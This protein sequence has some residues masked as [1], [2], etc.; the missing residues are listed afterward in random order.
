M[1]RPIGRRDF[2]NGVAV[3]IGVLGSG[4]AGR[5]GARQAAA[6]PGRRTRPVITRRC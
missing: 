1:H 6:W 2:L 5:R 3:G 4:L